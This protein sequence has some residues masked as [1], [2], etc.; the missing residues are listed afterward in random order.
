MKKGS[1][2]GHFRRASLLP[3]A[4]KISNTEPFKEQIDKS[5]SAAC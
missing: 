5:F 1:H 2:L 3:I 4:N